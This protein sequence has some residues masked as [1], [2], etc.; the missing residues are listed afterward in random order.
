MNKK[1]L[2]C[3]DSDGTAIDS[4]TIKHVRCFGPIAIEIFGMSEYAQELLTLWNNYNLYESTR[5]INRFKGLKRFLEEAALKNDKLDISKY[6]EWCNS[7]SEF[8]NNSIK[9]AYDDT[10]D[11]VLGKALEWSIL[12]NENIK[13]I[14]KEDIK[15]FDGVAET[16][17][18]LKDKADIAIV[19][20]ANREAIDDEWEREGLLSYVKETLDQTFGTKEMMLRKLAKDYELENIIMLGD[21]LLDLKAAQDAGVLFYPIIVNEEK[22]SFEEFRNIVVDKFLDG[23]YKEKLEKEYIEKFKNVLK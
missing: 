18:L 22:K 7:T 14:P 21:S 6:L 5:G 1:F 17:E 11:E 2:V 16:L 23:T 20:S 8:S 15:A 9:K 3:L 10:K 13:K 19:S 12:V 4:M